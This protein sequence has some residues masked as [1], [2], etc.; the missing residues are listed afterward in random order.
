MKVF[1]YTHDPMLTLVYLPEEAREMFGEEVLEDCGVEVPD[2]LAQELHDTYD[3]LC[4]LSH[5]V[6]Q[7]SKAVKG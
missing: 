3:K 7:I 1:I 6:A 2:A 5:Q 4:E